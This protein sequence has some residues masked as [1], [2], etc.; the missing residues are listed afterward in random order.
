[1]TFIFRLGFNLIKKKK[2]DK[3]IIGITETH[4]QP[5]S[6][7]LVSFKGFSFYLVVPYTCI[8]TEKACPLVKSTQ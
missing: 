7:R 6:S 2:Y 8:K 1:M 4:F 3:A 5:D